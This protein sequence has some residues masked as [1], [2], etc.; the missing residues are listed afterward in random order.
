MQTI[1]SR[2]SA[3]FSNAQLADGDIRR[4]DGTKQPLRALCCITVVTILPIIHASA[5]T[6]PSEPSCRT[7]NTLERTDH[8]ESLLAVR[9]GARWL[10][11]PNGNDP[12]SAYRIDI[13]IS[14]GKRLDFRWAAPA[15]PEPEVLYVSTLAR[16]D[17]PLSLQRNAA[18]GVLSM[19][20]PF[21]N[22]DWNEIILAPLDDPEHEE[23]TDFKS[24]FLRYHAANGKLPD[25]HLSE[26]KKVLDRWH[27]TRLWLVKEDTE[28]IVKDALSEMPV[29]ER[30]ERRGAERLIRVEG[31]RKEVSWIEFDTQAPRPADQVLAVALSFST[32]M[33]SVFEY[34]FKRR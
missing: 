9:Q 8:N 21:I 14:K 30:A 27:N 22:D 1:R 23:Y 17:H 24:D 20:V 26:L 29:R 28:R 2:P 34:Y 19:F 33:D 13:D 25:R 12:D 3:R 11:C 31:G 10:L 18:A 32:R 6:K 15:S 5:Q 16:S 4:R 7:A